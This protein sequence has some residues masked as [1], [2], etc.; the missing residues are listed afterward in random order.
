MRVWGWLASSLFAAALF[1]TPWP[2]SVVDALYSRGVYP[3]LQWTL[4]AA[5]NLVPI[6]V[7]DLLIGGAT[8]L[9]VFRLVR[10]FN[11]VSR[12]GVLAV[13]WEGARRTVR[14]AAVVVALF[15]CAWGCNY[16]RLPLESRLG[17]GGESATSSAALRTAIADAGALAARV[18]PAASAAS[19]EYPALAERLYPRLNA[20]LRTL[21]LA[22]LSRPG[23]PKFSLLLT[24]FFTRAGVDGMVNPLALESLVHPE[25][26]PFERAS[27]L[28]H[29]WSH[30]A[31]LADEAEA[32]AVGFF[33][34]MQGPAELAYSGSVYL[35]LEAAAALPPADRRHVWPSLDEKVRGDLEAIGRRLQRRQP[36]IQHAASEVYDRYLKANR[37]ADGTASYSR[38]LRL[39]LAEP[40]RASMT[41]AGTGRP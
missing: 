22:P 19:V 34:C 40:I 14:A 15:M 9:A 32:S 4:T 31:G 37:V 41:S 23:R 18:R 38:A 28:A 27:V 30:L 25:L 7:M 33:A 21:Q 13:V 35:I 16:R 5:S 39:I 8:A 36:R 20:A 24:P 26:L 6:A 3:R 11:G 1:L 12:R 29:E 17:S 2:A 10:L